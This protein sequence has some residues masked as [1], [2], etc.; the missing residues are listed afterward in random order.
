[1]CSDSSSIFKGFEDEDENDDEDEPVIGIFHT[2][3][4]TN[5]RGR[6]LTRRRQGAKTQRG[7]AANKNSETC[8]LQK[9]PVGRT[10]RSAKAWQIRWFTADR[11]TKRLPRSALPFLIG[12]NE[13]FPWFVHV[14]RGRK[15][16]RRSRLRFTSTRQSAA[17][18]IQ[19]SSAREPIHGFALPALRLCLF[20]LNFGC[21]VPAE[22]RVPKAN[23]TSGWND[24]QCWFVATNGVQT[25][26]KTFLYLKN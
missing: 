16:C 22:A 24:F 19:K 25:P 11:R 17:T 13:S 21:S 26:E 9:T 6:L 5:P 10:C 20:A 4:E 14:A 1:L 8:D 7:Q 12:A 23:Y 15:R 3:S 18:T 2:G